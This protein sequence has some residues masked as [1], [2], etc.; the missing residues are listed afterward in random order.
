MDLFINCSPFIQ[1]GIPK[2]PHDTST[3]LKKK[4][5]TFSPPQQCNNA[6]FLLLLFI[7]TDHIGYFGRPVHRL[8]K[9][10]S[11]RRVSKPKCSCMKV[12][13]RQSVHQFS[14]KPAY[15]NTV[16]RV[17]RSAVYYL[18]HSY[19]DCFYGFCCPLIGFY[20]GSMFC[21]SQLSWGLL[22]CYR[23]VQGQFKDSLFC[24]YVYMKTWSRVCPTRK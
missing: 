5:I 17:N 20:G 14:T 10:S 21:V 3:G 22:H 2:W 19:H 12:N 11:L 7:S 9:W 16:Y 1:Q 18:W 13:V 8:H 24:S 15:T 6:P 23:F 4:K